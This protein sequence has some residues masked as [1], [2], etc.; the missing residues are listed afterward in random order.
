MNKLSV[1]ISVLVFGLVCFGFTLP[2]PATISQNSAFIQ[3]MYLFQETFGKDP[4][5]SGSTY[6]DAQNGAYYFT[7]KGNVIFNMNDFNSDTVRY[8]W[9][10]YQ[11]TNSAITYTLGNEFYYPGKWDARWDVPEPDYKKG[12]SRKI[13][14]VIR[15]LQKVNCKNTAY[16]LS[17]NANEKKAADKRHKGAN[18]SGL[19]LFPYEET[20]EMKFYTWFYKQIPFLA[21][22]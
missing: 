22:L 3:Q 4:C 8:Y 18:A 10:K 21:E 6:D 15:T 5:S 2:K 7:K 11:I 16:M 9:G 13:T 12:K 17:F 1:L 19:G 14:P 20:K